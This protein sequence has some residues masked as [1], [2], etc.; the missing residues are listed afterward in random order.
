MNRALDA[1]FG[2]SDETVLV[3]QQ[4]QLSLSPACTTN[5]KATPHSYLL[6]QATTHDQSLHTASTSPSPSY[7]FQAHQ[8]SPQLESA[9][10][11]QSGTP[12]SSMLIADRERAIVLKGMYIVPASENCHFKTNARFVTDCIDSYLA[13]NIMTLCFSIM[14]FLLTIKLFF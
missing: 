4:T 3:T 13:Y 11:Y 6:Q 9:E 5:G 14:Q 7:N 1:L 12:K 10:Q 8:P 2:D